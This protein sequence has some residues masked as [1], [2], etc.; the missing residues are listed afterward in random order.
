LLNDNFGIL[1][2]SQSPPSLPTSVVHSPAYFLQ[3]TGKNNIKSFPVS[4]SFEARCLCLHRGYPGYFKKQISL[5]NNKTDI[6][7]LPSPPTPRRSF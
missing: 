6:L 5:H 7:R 3:L 2:P 4:V 1:A